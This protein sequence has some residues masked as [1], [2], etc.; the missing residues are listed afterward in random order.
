MKRKFDSTTEDIKFFQF[1][2]SLLE[3]YEHDKQFMANGQLHT[4]SYYSMQKWILAQKL[5]S[6]DLILR[7]MLLDA[8]MSADNSVPGSGSYVPWFV[9]NSVKLQT[10]IRQS[11]QSYLDM[12]I[13]RVFSQEGH[14]IF[15]TIFANCGPLTKMKLQTHHEL[16]VVMKYRNSYRFP[17]APNAQFQTMV[18]NDGHIE[19]VN[20]IVITI[21]GA[22]ETVAEIN[23]ILQWNHETSRPIV[24]MARSFHEEIIATLATN[25]I[26]GSLSILPI[27][28]GN[29]IETINMAADICSATG[30][31]LISPHFGDVIT[32]AIMDRDKWG[33]IESFTWAGQES[34]IRSQKDTTRHRNSLI[35]KIESIEEEELRELYS[36]RI[37]SLNADAF[38]IKVPDRSKNIL[39]DLDSMIK[40]YGAFVMSGAVE[41]PL[42]FLPSSFVD[43]A[44]ASSKTLKDT[45]LNIGGFLVR[46]D[47]EVV[48]G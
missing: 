46:V 11:S 6:K 34:R 7:N 42:G 31:E 17:I 48:A 9:Y 24:I 35:K 14:D 43:S 13:D 4:C 37:M 28:Y 40:H 36:K 22:P 39:S 44:Q 21:E 16:D 33:E 1:T 47:D 8:M 30:A 29:T 15:R 41:T 3:L 18:G 20:P 38:E 2:K 10:P 27:Q 19:L 12:T 5:D 23:P 26:R 45:I 32:S 25:W